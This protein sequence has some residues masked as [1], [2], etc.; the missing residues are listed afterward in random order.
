MEPLATALMPS[1]ILLGCIEEEA[2]HKSPQEGQAVFGQH[3]KLKLQNMDRGELR[4]EAMR[5][6]MNTTMRAL[7]RTASTSHFFVCKVWIFR[8]FN[9]GVFLL[10][11][12]CLCFLKD[13]W[14]SREGGG[15]IIFSKRGT[16]KR[17]CE[18]GGGDSFIR[19]PP[20]Y[21]PVPLLGV[22]PGTAEKRVPRS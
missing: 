1:F 6:C 8:S 5:P 10:F 7:W 19:P 17:F 22:E 20:L 9:G 3:P 15:L 14:S 12:L 21:L 18:E 4:T 11:F 2:G 13:S 16:Y